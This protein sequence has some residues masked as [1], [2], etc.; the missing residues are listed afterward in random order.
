[1]RGL[2]VTP[3]ALFVLNTDDKE[4]RNILIGVYEITFTRTPWK[5]VTLRK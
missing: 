5:R 1:M 3:L 4:S 2:H